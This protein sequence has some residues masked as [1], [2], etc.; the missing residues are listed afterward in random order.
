[1]SGELHGTP[2]ADQL[3]SKRKRYARLLDEGRNLKR[4]LDWP[5]WEAGTDKLIE[6]CQEASALREMLHEAI[7]AAE[8]HIAD[9][10]KTK[11]AARRHGEAMRRDTWNKVLT[12]IAILAAIGTG[13]GVAVVTG[14][15]GSTRTV[16]V[17]TA[18]P[19]PSVTRTGSTSGAPLRGP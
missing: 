1:V 2:S 9:A 17:K 3:D 13:V 14:A 15:S 12:I 11:Q 16:T 8:R 19:R 6:A 10:D 4:G 18:S 7:K 5:E